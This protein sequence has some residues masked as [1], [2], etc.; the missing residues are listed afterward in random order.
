MGVKMMR[1]GKLVQLAMMQQQFPFRRKE[2]GTVK[3]LMPGALDQSGTDIH[4]VLPRRLPQA[5]ARIAFRNGAG[6]RVRR[7]VAPAAVERLRQQNNGRGLLRRAANVLHR[8]PQVLLTVPAYHRHLREGELEGVHR[9]VAAAVA[10]T[11]LSGCWVTAFHASSW[12]SLLSF[13]AS[14]SFARNAGMGSPMGLR[15]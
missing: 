12:R 5:Q 8:T 14:G 7:F 10:V 13:S 3:Q 9:T 6:M 11:P 2:H 4:P 1:H 15:R